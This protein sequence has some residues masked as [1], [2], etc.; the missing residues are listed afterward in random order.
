MLRVAKPTSPMSMGSWLLPA[1]SGL[2][3][4]AAA[5]DLTGRCAGLGAAAR[6]RPRP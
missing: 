4:A 1:H 5:S 3:S 6:A 2:V